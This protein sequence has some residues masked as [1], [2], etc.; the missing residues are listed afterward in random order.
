MSKSYG[1]TIALDEPEA[2]IRAKLK[3]MV[4][5]PARIKRTDPG[6]PEIC[7]VGDL[8]K[9]FSSQASVALNAKAGWR[10]L[11]SPSW[12]QCG[13]RENAIARTITLLSNPCSPMAP[14]APT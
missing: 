6:N 8:H 3:T 9:V 12:R 13:R 7:P 2:D 1:N 11:S 4:T 5:D 10:T 14:L